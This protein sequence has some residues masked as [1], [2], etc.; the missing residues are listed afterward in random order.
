LSLATGRPGF[1]AMSHCH[2]SPIVLSIAPRLG[3]QAASSTV[4]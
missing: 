1:S 2:V 3:Q 4:L